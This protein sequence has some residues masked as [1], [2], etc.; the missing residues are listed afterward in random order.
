MRNASALCTDAF[1][2]AFRFSKINHKLLYLLG[3]LVLLPSFAFAQA[4]TGTLSGT[5]KDTSG[6][7]VP[8]AMVTVRNTATGATR[9]VQTGSD[10]VYTVPGL[11]PAPYDVTVS[12]TGFADYKAQ[13]TITVGSHVTLDAPLSVSAV[14]TTVEVVAVA[15]A[16]VNTQTQEVS[17]IITPE[18]VQQLPS[19]TRN[20]YDFVALSG[21]ISGGDRSASTNNPQLAAGGGQNNTSYRGAG[22][23][24]NGQRFSDTEILLDGAENINI[25]DNTIGLLIP[26]DAVQEF[27]VITN[28]F[29]VQ[30][31]RAPA[32]SSTSPPNPEATLSTGTH[33]SSIAFRHTRQIRLTIM[34]QACRRDNMHAISLAMT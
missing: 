10:G 13:A 23:S 16:E 15:A 7:S 18:Q 30:Y 2:C 20:P 26:Q 1:V 21:N 32:G 28:N 29:N 25:F 33:G 12:K 4:D 6:A 19:L 22:Y 34:R 17:Q 3:L 5:V 8:D 24:I 31:G 27:R 11:A 14:S 9:V